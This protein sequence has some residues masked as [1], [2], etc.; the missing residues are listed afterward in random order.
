MD[1]ETILATDRRGL[2]SKKA[3]PAPSDQG[4]EESNWVADAAPQ[5][6]QP[7]FSGKR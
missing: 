2:V 5:V 3:A 6:F 4:A 1:E 7:L